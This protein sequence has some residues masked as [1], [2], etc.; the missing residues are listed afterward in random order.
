MWNTDSTR[1]DSMEMDPLLAGLVEFGKC[2]FL[3]MGVVYNVPAG[4]VVH[5]LLF[6]LILILILLDFIFIRP[7]HPFIITVL[8]FDCIRY[9]ITRTGSD[10]L[11][12]SFDYIFRDLYLPTTVYRCIALHCI[13]ISIYIHTNLHPTHSPQY[14]TSQTTPHN[15]YYNSYLHIRQNVL[16]SRRT[17]L[18]LQM[19][20]LPTLHRPLFRLRPTRPLRPRKDRSSRLCLLSTFCARRF[21]A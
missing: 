10:A 18:R 7:D 17:L 5:L 8:F 9:L 3:R 15:L 1:F 16:Q 13:S 6:I 14:I 11:S 4:P 20:L 12:I 21:L 19:R 2:A